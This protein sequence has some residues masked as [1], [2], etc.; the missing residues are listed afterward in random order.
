MAI[1]FNLFFIHLCLLAMA[2]ISSC[3]LRWYFEPE[4][5]GQCQFAT[6][7]NIMHPCQNKRLNFNFNY[8]VSGSSSRWL[9]LWR[10]Y[11]LSTCN[12]IMSNSIWRCLNANILPT[13]CAVLEYAAFFKLN[14]LFQ[15]T[16]WI[17]P[18]KEKSIVL[19]LLLLLLFY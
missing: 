8:Y 4:L 7:I 11:A 18:L 3:Q 2:D 16:L 5:L 13:S 10:C 14:K 6:E 15:A 1:H 17:L 9:T 12:V 19:L